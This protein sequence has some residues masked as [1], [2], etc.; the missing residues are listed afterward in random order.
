MASTPTAPASTGLPD[1]A[2]QARADLARRLSISDDQITLLEST[3]VTWPDASLGC[4]QPGMMYAQV[5]TPGYLIRLQ[6]GDR[7]YEYHAGRATTVIYC[8]Q[9]SPPITGA[10]S[11]S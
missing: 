6:V 5:L 10:P 1:L 7:V 11:D 8:E 3:P 2:A 4:P 9:P